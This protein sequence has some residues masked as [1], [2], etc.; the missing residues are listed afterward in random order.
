MGRRSE[1]CRRPGRG[2]VPLPRRSPPRPRP[3]CRCHPTR[4]GSRPGHRQERLAHLPPRL[5]DARAASRGGR[6]SRQGCPQAQR[7]LP[8]GHPRHLRLQLPQAHRQGPRRSRRHPRLPTREDKHRLHRPQRRRQ[9]PPR[10]R[11]RSA[12]LP[13]W[14]PRPF[15]RRRRPRQRHRPGQARNTLNKRLAAW[16]TPDL[17]LVDELGYLSFDARGAD[18][19]YQV[20]NKRYQ[21]ASTIVTIMWNHGSSPSCRR[22]LRNT[23]ARSASVPTGSDGQR[24][25]RRGGRWRRGL[26]R[27]RPFHRR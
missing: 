24:A 27:S 16:A 13:P 10:K 14:L 23:A 4:R 5:A 1:T 15:R 9:N 3:R 2:Q 25:S 19:L 22:R 7:H 26:R 12:R 6:G 21:R 17:L 18:L 20:F 11:P 8:L